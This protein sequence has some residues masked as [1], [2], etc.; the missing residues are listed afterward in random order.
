MHCHL[1]ITGADKRK[2][3][4]RAATLPEAEAPVRVVLPFATIHWAP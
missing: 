3:L 4:E 2:A 1:L